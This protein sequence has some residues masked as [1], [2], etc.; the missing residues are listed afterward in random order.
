M[1]TNIFLDAIL[2][3]KLTLNV[4]NGEGAEPYWTKLVFFY[5]NGKKREKNYK[6][7]FMLQRVTILIYGGYVS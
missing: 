3:K 4:K 7:N 6:Q 2:E 1:T 5:E